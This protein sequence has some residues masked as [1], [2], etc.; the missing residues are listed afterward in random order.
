MRTP[1][2]YQRYEKVGPPPQLPVAQ[3]S[4][5]ATEGP[6]TLTDPLWDGAA[7]VPGAVGRPAGA[8]STGTGGLD[9][10]VAPAVALL[11]NAWHW[12]ALPASPATV[13]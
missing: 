12:I 7:I 8:G 4:V 6:G 3:V 5:L 10:W 2:R 13:V 1:F 11:A 9:T